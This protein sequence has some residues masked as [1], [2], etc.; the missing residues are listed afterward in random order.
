MSRSDSL[1][2]NP[3][4]E[5]HS[6]VHV[7][8]FEDPCP[9]G[10]VLTHDGIAQI[11]H[12]KY[13]SGEYSHLDNLCN[14]MW[15]YCTETFLPMS[16]APNMVTSLGGLACLLS[17]LATWYYLPQFEP[18]PDQPVP[19]ELLLFNGICV[20]LYFTF[21]CMDG[22]QARRTNSSSPLG[23][24]FDHGVDCFANL[25]MLSVCQS[26][27]MM[28]PSQYYLWSHLGLQVAFFSPQWEEYHTG[29]LRHSYGKWMGV[30]EV[31]YGL[32]VICMANSL[33]DFKSFYEQTVQDTLW[34]ILPISTLP[35]TPLSP[36]LF[37]TIINNFLTM[38]M[39]QLVLTLW[40]M[41][42]TSIVVGCWYRTA[43]YINNL[44]K[45]CAALT[46][47]ASPLLV[48]FMVLVVL[49]E[50]AVQAECRLISL[51]C[52][53]C[54]CFITVKIIV[55]SMAKMSYA[56]IQPDILPLL[57]VLGFVTWEY[58]YSVL[59]DQPRRL[60]PLGFH[61]LLQCLTVYYLVR[62]FHWTSTAMHQLCQKL[63]VYVFTIKPK[64][65]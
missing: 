9:A 37:V 33:I 54:L 48:T 57:C 13:V 65:H 42:A 64:H 50:E 49:P 41:L 30:T 44:P 25:T 8:L 35:Q 63:D 18:R 45:T 29:I 11:A 38:P 1:D 52:G 59:W 20:F 34:P 14:P 58:E 51:A 5:D 61:F 3:N 7:W 31:N 62:I 19:P 26:F 24:L 36:S 53:L 16:M 32:A 17:Y 56:C 46:M 6:K 23:Q 47:F 4:P 28:G 39:K 21:D 15:T 22:K 43:L 12:H 27:L 40:L 10:T 55:L 60:K 2:S